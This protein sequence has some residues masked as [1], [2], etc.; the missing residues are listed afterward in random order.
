ML[1]GTSLIEEAIA[2]SR[3]AFC[4]ASPSGSITCVSCATSAFASARVSGQRANS[5]FV[6]SLTAASRDPSASTAATS[7]C[8]GVFQSSS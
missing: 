7:S 1:R 4:C 8:S 3:G 6:T 2:M 5:T